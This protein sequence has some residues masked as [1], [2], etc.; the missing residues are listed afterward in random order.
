MGG[1]EALKITFHYHLMDR[2]GSRAGQCS[3]QWRGNLCKP[4][5]MTEEL[6]PP[7][8]PPAVRQLHRV[9]LQ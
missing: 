8:Q 5:E 4:D 1:E 9:K 3:A 2:R 6:E 7:F